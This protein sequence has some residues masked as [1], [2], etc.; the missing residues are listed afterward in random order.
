MLVAAQM[1]ACCV[2]A[3]VY[4]ARLDARP[5]LRQHSCTM[6]AEIAAPIVALPG[7]LATAM[8]LTERAGI[9]LLFEASENWNFVLVGLV[10]AI[11]ATFE[12]AVELTEELVPSKLLPAVDESIKQVTS[13]NAV[14][15]RH[16]RECASH[17]G[18]SGMSRE[19]SLGEGEPSPLDDHFVRL[20]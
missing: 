19:E 11:G 16:G 20:S 15:G 17:G 7:L 8:P 5:A 2:S 1:T 12:R 14:L 18:G 4:G 13:G 10:L 6:Q 3:M 9:E